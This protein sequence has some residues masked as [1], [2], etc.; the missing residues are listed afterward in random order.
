MY[1]FLPYLQDGLDA[2]LGLLLVAGVAARRIEL[3]GNV[4]P[5]RGLW[6]NIV[7]YYYGWEVDYRKKAWVRAGCGEGEAGD[8][9]GE[10]QLVARGGNLGDRY[11]CDGVEGVWAV[12]APVQE[13]N[14]KLWAC[15][16]SQR[17]PHC[18]R[19]PDCY[20]LPE[21]WCRS[22]HGLYIGRAYPVDILPLGPVLQ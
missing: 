16:C 1:P 11:R 14:S 21:R 18:C 13:G 20:R 3:A 8:E 15:E 19:A 2:A 6:H 7:H 22:S 4:S 12:V 5:Y 10:V 17:I 9:S